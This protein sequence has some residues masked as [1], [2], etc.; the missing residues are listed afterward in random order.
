MFPKLTRMKQPMTRGEFEE[1]INLTHEQI[2]TG[3]LHPNGLDGLLDVRHLPNGRIDMLSVNEMV[4]L[5][6]NMSHQMIA[7]PMGDMLR[8]MAERGDSDDGDGEDKS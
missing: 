5:N 1:R 2:H 4:R 6:A 8:T 3:K 7:T